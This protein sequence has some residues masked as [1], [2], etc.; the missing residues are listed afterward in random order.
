M[1]EALASAGPIGYLVLVGALVGL[2]VCAVAG[3]YALRRRRVSLSLMMVVPMI[4]LGLGS[5]ASWN[6]LSV[7]PWWTSSHPNDP[8][9]AGNIGDP[10]AK[11]FREPETAFQTFSVRERPS[12]TT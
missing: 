2:V 5:V 4:L 11:L 3:A 12:G 10:L 8:S 1:S 7:A 6:A 9:H